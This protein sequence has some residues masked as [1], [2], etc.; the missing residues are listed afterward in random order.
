[1]NHPVFTLGNCIRLIADAVVLN[2]LYF[3]SFVIRFLMVMLW[4]KEYGPAH[5][6]DLLQEYMN[7]FVTTFWA[8]TLIALT[9]YWFSGFYGRNRIYRGRFKA[10]M[11]IQA[12]SLAYLIFGFI[13]YFFGPFSLFPRLALLIAWGITMVAE[14]ALRLGAGFWKRI[15]QYE[16]RILR[17]EEDS[18]VRHV[19]VIGGA[20]YIGSVL[21]RQLL[22]DGYRVRVLDALLYGD[23]SVCELYDHPRFEMI[24]GDFRDVDSVVRAMQ[25]TD[26]VV[27]LGALV[28]DP[29]CALDEQLTKEINLAATRMIAEAARGMGVRRFV[30][31]STCSVYGA[32]D[33]ILTEESRLNPLSLYAHTKVEAERIL[34]AMEGND[35]SPVI[36]RFGTIYGLSPRPRFDLAI[37]LLTAKATVDGEI[38]IFGGGQWRPFVHVADAAY[39]IKVCLEKRV[40]V[41]S[42]QIFNVGSDDQNFKIIQVG[43]L[44]CRLI[45]DAELINIGDD[46]DKRNYRVSFGKIREVLGFTPRYTVEDGVRELSRTI[47]DGH[48]VDYRAAQ[49]SNYLSLQEESSMLAARASRISLLYDLTPSD[50]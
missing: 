16:A 43:E 27:H 40:G 18:P 4:T 38:T 19:L 29:A 9:V 44:V 41:V 2:A 21:C 17:L 8:L 30:F 34:L 11:I 31:A 28:G 39:A 22:D 45:S 25:N 46:V 32:S 5:L 1:M 12:V 23:E 48:I 15:A 36:L 6:P 47:L 10:L 42:G 7:T 3:A 26:A 13:V 49:Y 33:S 20:G 50:R 14:L 37:N 24:K 35:F